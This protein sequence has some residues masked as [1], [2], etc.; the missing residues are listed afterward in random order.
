VSVSRDLDRIL[1]GDLAFLDEAIERGLIR[2][3]IAT[4]L[5]EID[6]ERVR[7]AR[8]LVRELE[9]NWPGVE[10]ILRM[11]EEILTGQ[12][13]IERLIAELRRRRG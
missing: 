5:T 2:T 8:V 1:A 4:E 9:I 13:Q 12:R 7:V 6:L 10:V 3:R 11:R